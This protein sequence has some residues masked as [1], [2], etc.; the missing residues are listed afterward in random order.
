[1]EL[2]VV[3]P[4][5]VLPLRDA[6]DRSDVDDFWSVWSKNVEAGLVDAYRGV[7]GPTEAGSS[8]FPGRG[9]LRIRSWRLG[10]RAFGG[11]AGRLHWISQNGE[12]DVQSPKYFVNSSL[13][14]VLLFRRRLKSVADVLKGIWNHGFT[15]SGW[16]A[17]PGY[18]NAVCRHGPCGPICSLHPW[19]QWVPPYLH[20]F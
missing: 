10:G 13:A 9:L 19:D 3:P 6:F 11:G 12:V 7:G 8:A 14:P 1:M 4:D 17:L 5:V 20:V 18:W 16:A 2:G 15:Q